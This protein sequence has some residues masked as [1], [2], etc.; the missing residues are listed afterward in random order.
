MKKRVIIILLLG[1]LLIFPLVQAQEQSQT[2]SGFNRFVD[3]VKMFFSSGDN[4]VMLAL[5]IREKELNSAME[6]IQNGEDD[7]ASRNIEN[8]RKKLQFVQRKVSS[9]IADD[10]IENIET[11]LGMIGDS[12]GFELYALEEEKT[13]LVA[14][15]VV[16]V[17]GSEGQTLTREMVKD[18]ESGEN[19]VGVVVG[20]EEGGEVGVQEGVMEIA[21]GIIEIDSQIAD[22]IVESGMDVDVETGMDIDPGRDPDATPFS[23]DG[24]DLGPVDPGPQGIVGSDHEPGVVDED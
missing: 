22:I 10:V 2:Y 20:G 18:E 23:P 1:I 24:D 5:E 4:K 16:E 17:E 11:T 13:Q 8:A 15:L 9:D 21:E 7:A 14:E 3:N 19:K 12:E 6:N